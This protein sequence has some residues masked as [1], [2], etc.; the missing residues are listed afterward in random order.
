MGIVY[1]AE[2]TKLKR[3]VAIKILPSA[4][5]ASEENRERFYR[6][7]RAAAALHHPHI[8]TVFE[9]DE[10]VPSDAP[11]GTEPSPFIAMEFVDGGTLKDEID[12]GPMDLRRAVTIAGQIAEALKAA[13]AKD[14]VHRDIKGS[15]VMLTPEGDA[16]VLDFG[17]A[18]TAQSTMLTRIGSTLG[19]AAYMSPEQARGEEVDARTDIWSL[20]VVLFEMIAGRLPF[21]GEYEKAVMYGI[22][23]ETPPPLTGLR[24]GVPMGL[25]W[26]VTKMLA[27]SPDERYQSCSDLIVD[28]KTVDLSASG[29]S[30]MSGAESV[31]SASVGTTQDARFKPSLWLTLLLLPLGLGLGWILFGSQPHSIGPPPSAKSLTLKIPGAVFALGTAITHDGSKMIGGINFGEGFGISAID[32]RTGSVQLLVR[33]YTTSRR[34]ISY[35]DEWFSYENGA[36]LWR[37]RISGGA[38]VLV[39]TAPYSLSGH[40]WLPDNSIVASVIETDSTGG[41][42]Y[43]IP[44]TGGEARLLVRSEEESYLYP[45][46]LH[47]NDRI[48]FTSQALGRDQEIATV[49]LKDGGIHKLDPGSPFGFSRSGHL[50]YFGA[51]TQA[52]NAGGPLL[53]RAFDASIPEFLGPPVTIEE[54]TS[55]SNIALDDHGT[56][57]STTLGSAQAQG[58]VSAH[59]YE[60]GESMAE[61]VTGL[62]NPSPQPNLS[63]DGEHVMLRINVDDH[64]ELHEYN[65]F[66]GIARS[67]TI[68]SD[69]DADN[70]AYS[71]DGRELVFESDNRLFRR[72]ANRSGQTKEYEVPDGAGALDW[73]PSG[74]LIV[75]VSRN[76]LGF[77]DLYLLDVEKENVTLLDAG[78][79]Q[80]AWPRFSPDE[81]FISFLKRNLG[82]DSYWVMSLEDGNR[83]QVTENVLGGYTAIFTA[84]GKYLYYDSQEGLNRVPIELDPYFQVMGPAEVVIGPELVQYDLIGDG[85][86]ILA[87]T[88]LNTNEG[89]DFFEFTV[90]TD[91]ATE[92]KQIAPAV[93]R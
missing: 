65:I 92:L 25:E 16:K 63:P 20:G 84:D 10:A 58:G 17:L 38:P 67:F 3:T 12:K 80:H 87:I 82:G 5:L 57:Y 47:N 55:H 56:Y 53:A 28:L 9:I 35:D 49:D 18:K 90:L 61:I 46:S 73:S 48:A 31:A 59:L 70:S 76:A 6:E 79:G 15:N 44:A 41:A 4:A 66:T 81:R 86:Q 26:I 77:G 30:R 11:H 54:N 34:S 40:A 52:S 74:R 1:K 83:I 89:D 14:I 13:H 7:A 50:L 78:D 33:G 32:L 36:E 85:N 64:Q 42:L 51:E 45:V 60:N 29:L 19:T 91:W 22:L 24:T 2:D 39:F 43:V 71:P 72:N 27:K 8:A 21:A 62:I 68:A 88:R 69:G 75:F 37:V 23:N 93:E